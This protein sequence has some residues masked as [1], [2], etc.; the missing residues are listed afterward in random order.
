MVVRVQG[1]ELQGRDVGMAVKVQHK[2]SL[3]MCSVS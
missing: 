3:W 2:E 1:G